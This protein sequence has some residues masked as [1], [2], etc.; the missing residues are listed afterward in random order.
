MIEENLETDK[1]EVLNEFSHTMAQ[2]SNEDELSEIASSFVAKMRKQNLKEI[3]PMVLNA[4][5]NNL[6]AKVLTITYESQITKSVNELIEFLN[7]NSIMPSIFKALMDQLQLKFYDSLY[8]IKKLE[9]KAPAGSSHELP[10]IDESENGVSSM[11]KMDFKTE[12]YLNKNFGYSLLD[13]NGD[14]IWCDSNCE[15]FF[16][17][18]FREEGP[19]NLF[20]LMIPFSKNFLIQKFGN[21]LF[22]DVN[23]VGSA[24]TFAYVIYSMSS[25]SKFLKCIKK[26]R[27]ENE[28]DFH[29]RM[30]SRTSTDAIY[31]QYLK[32]L[33]SR[34]SLV[35]LKF[36]RGELKS[37]M[38][39]QKYNFNLTESLR[40]L[41]AKVPPVVKK[42]KKR[43]RKPAIKLEEKKEPVP[44][45]DLTAK[46]NDNNDDKGMHYE[47]GNDGD[48]VVRTAILL[49][50]RLSMN[51][52]QFDYSK[53]CEDPIIKNYEQKIIKKVC[54]TN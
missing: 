22:R 1:M 27:F 47:S 39:N 36:T 11:L 4:L 43:G 9:E 37:I 54:K 40:D 28:E 15:K 3:H 35:L 46:L 17:F 33:S 53:L 52:P 25:V 7:E 30:K 45:E 19:K 49:E 13:L 34:A 38:T 8:Q 18:K 16:E 51:V 26:L 21:E 41:A 42:I 14:F 20:D 29:N 50:T 31:H 24:I 48:T 12:R 2:I 5:C 23:S 10:E 32:A 44:Q 6:C